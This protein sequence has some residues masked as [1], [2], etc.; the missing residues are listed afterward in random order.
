MASVFRSRFF[1]G[2]IVCIFAGAALL[3]GY[4][5]VSLLVEAFNEHGSPEGNALLFVLGLILLALSPGAI[6][7]A[8]V[9][10]TSSSSNSGGKNN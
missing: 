6:I 7:V 1:R 3:L 4:S 9:Y 8:V 10:W 2:L 5:G